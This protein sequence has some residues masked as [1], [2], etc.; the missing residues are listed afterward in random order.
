MA[1]LAAGGAP[2]RGSNRLLSVIAAGSMLI[3][4][5]DVWYRTVVDQDHHAELLLAYYGAL[6][7]LAVLAL[8]VRTAR[9]MLAVD[10]AML[11]AAA[12]ECVN[13]LTVVTPARSPDAAGAWSMTD[14][15]ALVHMAA[16]TLL[17]GRPIYGTHWPQIF[18]LFHAGPTP[19]MSGGAVTSLDYPPLGPLLTAVPMALGLPHPPGAVAATAMLLAAAAVMFVLMPAPWRPVA[20]ITCFGAGV[21][22]GYALLGY[23][24]VME[25]PFLIAAV[26]Y[27][28]RTGQGG[29]LGRA[30]VLRAGCLG[31]AACLHQLSWFLAPFLVAGVFL[32]R[33][34]ELPQRQALAVTARYAA[35]AAAVF[36]AVNAPFAAQGPGNWLGGVLAPMTQEAVPTG[37]GLI[38][39]ATYFTAGSGALRLYSVAGLLLGAGLLGLMVLLPRRLALAA[40]VLP[41]LVFYLSLRSQQD[42]FDLTV[43]LWVTAAATVRIS[44]LD[45]A[46]QW[47]PALLRTRARRALAV[48]VLLAPA[49]LCLAVAIGTPPPLRM[50]VT[51]LT[52]SGG[53][54]GALTPSGI[55][56]R[57]LTSLTVRVTNTSSTPLG[58]HFATSTG[59]VASAYWTVVSGPALLPPGRSAVYVLRAPGG[60]GVRGPRPGGRLILRAFTPAPMTLSSRLVG[61]GAG[62]GAGR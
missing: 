45:R 22:P 1:R 16:R 58:P 17:Q 56:Q 25:L 47:R 41:W 31:A 44:D 34:G 19:L 24:G 29:R 26:A 55:P 62:A 23:P 37:E 11:T 28:P 7:V 38:G 52:A 21:L 42:Y 8:T 53:G 15:G 50:A 59:P 54:R 3:G 46:A 20:L 9:A 30:G 10:A 57:G 14:E 18:T 43:P 12:A 33:R 4:A 32:V 61:I 27:W 36:L 49:A 39:I 40:P 60:A 6:L 35:V 51:A 48:P 13:R 5:R 2:P